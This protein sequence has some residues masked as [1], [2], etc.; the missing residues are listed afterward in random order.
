MLHGNLSLWHPR[1]DMLVHCVPNQTLFDSV[2]DDLLCMSW[3][4]RKQLRESFMG[5][6]APPLSLLQIY[7]EIEVAQM[8]IACY[9]SKLSLI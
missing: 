8:L 6:W 1:V 3:C 7:R 9:Q 2:T 5:K 4:I